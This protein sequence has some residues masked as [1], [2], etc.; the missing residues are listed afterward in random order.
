MGIDTDPGTRVPVLI[1]VGYP[2]FQ[3]PESPCTNGIDFLIGNDIWLQC[4]PLPDK[5]IQQ[6]VPTRAAARKAQNPPNDDQD[7]PEDDHISEND[8]LM[9]KPLNF[10]A[11]IESVTDRTKL[12]DSQKADPKLAHLHQK[13]LE[14]KT[15]MRDVA[16]LYYYCKKLSS[17]QRI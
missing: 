9:G 12:I 14:T 10:D 15:P 1:P 5:V 6:A 3:I 17:L 16:F 2:N 13:A 8:H 7:T 11:S 4:H